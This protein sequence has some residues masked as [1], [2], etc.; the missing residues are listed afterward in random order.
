MKHTK[1][2]V[3]VG[4]GILVLITILVM[5]VAKQARAYQTHVTGV[6]LPPTPVLNQKD[7]ESNNNEIMTFTNQRVISKVTD[8][9]IGLPDKD[10]FV[11]VVQRQ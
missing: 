6:D 1:Q 10:K 3:I 9:A 8:L 5:I 2:M 4:C 7:L 11:Y